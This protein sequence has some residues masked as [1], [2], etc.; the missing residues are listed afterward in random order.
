MEL[1]QTSLPLI[2]VI[3]G[4]LLT[5]IGTYFRLRAERKRAIALAL[6]D[7]LEIRH[8]ICGIEVVLGAVNKRF[9]PP[10]EATSMLLGLI[11][12]ISPVDA[13][14]H[15]RYDSAVSL[16]AGID[17]LLAFN[18]RSKNTLPNMLISLRNVA[19]SAGLS[20]NDINQ[21]EST[22][23]LNLA[24][25]LDEAVIEL[26]R[27]YSF[28]TKLKVKRLIANSGALP[29]EIDAMLDELAKLENIDEQK[30]VT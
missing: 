15:K 20:I 3:I 11:E 13:D 14:V 29:P 28:R 12:K 17:P 26:A 22:L 7:L 9:T 19:E 24:P 10:A 16:L 25:H 27:K 6:S 2:G 4:S 8:H 23:R 1:F 18:L 30:Q 5:G 21:F